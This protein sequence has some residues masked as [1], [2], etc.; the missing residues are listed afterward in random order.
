MK[1]GPVIDRINYLR[2][3]LNEHNHRYY[4]LNEPAV[5]DYEYDLLMQELIRLE[6]E[7]PQYADP[8]SPSVRIGDDRNQEFVQRRHMNAMYS[9]GNTY[10]REEVAEFDQRVRKAIGDQVEY[11]C[12][13]KYDGA[14]ISLTYEKGRLLYALTRGDGIIGDDVTS[15]IKTIKSIPLVIGGTDYPDLFEIRGE[16]ILYRAIFDQLNAERIEDG[17]LPFANPRNAASGTLKMQNSAQ[18]AKRKLNCLLYYLTG[19]VLPAP[20]HSGN[21]EWA[22]K[23]GFAIPVYTEIHTSVEGI[24]SFIHRWETAR[25]KLPFDTDGIVIKVNSL[26]QQAELGFTAKNPRWAIAFKYPPEQAETTL[27][28]VDFQV[29]RTGAITPVAN[30]EPV[31]LGGTTVKRASLHNADQIALL[32]LHIGDRVVIEKG[33]EIIPKIT[34]VNKS[35]RDLFAVPVTFTARCPECDTPLVRDQGEAR[36]YCPNEDGCPPQIKG[37]IEHFISRKAMNIDGLGE[38]TVDQL[39]R[40]GLLKRIPDLYHLTENQLIRLDR[41]AE[42]SAQNLVSAIKSSAEI[43]FERVLYAIGI[44]FV[45]ETVAKKLARSLGSIDR[46]MNASREELLAVDEVGDKIADSVLQFFSLEKNRR[47]I[48][49]LKQWGLQFETQLGIQIDQNLPLSGKS[50]VVTGTFSQFSRDMLK[51]L[52]EQQGG[53]I[54]SSVTSKTSMIIAGQNMGPEKLKKAGK[55]NIPLVSEDEF[56]KMI[57]GA[58]ASTLF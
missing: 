34:G 46:I 22:R 8:L 23:A 6:Q 7:Y 41:F 37:R 31:Y 14:A 1:Q 24:F 55:F 27:L 58:E 9:L 57:S 18:V 50:V 49:D 19:S 20:T 38:E 10:S 56:V 47:L 48:G 51:E 30:L 43:S 28:S 21:L 33:G 3:T 11:V 2:R 39:Y 16:I 4:V 17:E 26:D 40:A 45:G 13:L 5:S 35:R 29:G 36:H 15:N 52:I 53:K 54:V 25:K 44:R 12:E 42:K 32:D